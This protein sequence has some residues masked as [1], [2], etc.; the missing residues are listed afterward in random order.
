MRAPRPIE[1]SVAL[2]VAAAVGF[3]LAKMNPKPRA[4]IAVVDSGPLP[5]AAPIADASVEAETVHAFVGY[6]VDDDDGPEPPDPK[7][8][9]V[10]E[11]IKL[12]PIDV[13]NEES[14]A[15]ARRWLGGGVSHTSQGNPAIGSHAISRAQCRA[16]LKGM[17]LQTPL[18]HAVCGRKWEV[19]IHTGEPRKA[20]VCI[21]TF[22]YPN[23]PC[24]LPFVFSHSIMAR[25]LCALSGKRLCKQEEWNTACEA[26]PNG[27]APRKYA[28]GDTLDLKICHTGREKSPR[29][30][31]DKALWK[32]CPTET[33]PAGSFPKCRSRL[34]VFDQHGNVAEAMTRMEGSI[35]YVQLKGS[36]FF[37]DGEMYADHCRY[38]PRWHVDPAEESFHTNYHLGFRCCRDV[39]PLEARGDAA[40]SA[41]E[42]SVPGWNPQDSSGAPPEDNPY[43]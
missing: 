36:A 1:L 18:Q 22:E 35:N 43:E 30:D 11:L 28:Y 41:P 32:S 12:I 17:I 16:G 21:D 14:L 13:R 6:T 40:V 7:T 20:A 19:P 38:D 5:D 2:A 29:C 23:R 37:Y 34:G 15:A 42:V 9:D 3:A 4:P 26:D 8:I 33:E 39:V 27:G 31:V 25:R 24:V 10:E